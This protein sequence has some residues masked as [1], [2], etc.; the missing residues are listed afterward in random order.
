M[1]N[2]TDATPIEPKGTKLD[3]FSGPIELEKAPPLDSNGSETGVWTNIL[4][5]YKIVK[6]VV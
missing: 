1:K 2:S 3:C 6:F 5:V 4:I